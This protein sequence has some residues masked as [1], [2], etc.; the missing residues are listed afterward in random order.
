VVGA[1]ILNL[2]CSGPDIAAAA[3]GAPAAGGWQVNNAAGAGE[4]AVVAQVDLTKQ[5]STR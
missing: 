2:G 1:R 5:R 3:C 4:V